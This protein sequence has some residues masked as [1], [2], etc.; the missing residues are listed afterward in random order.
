MRI[1]TLPGD[2]GKRR[3]PTR[4]GRGEGSGK[5]K[6]CGRGTKGY[7]SRSGS[8]RRWGDEGGQMPLIQRLPKRGFKPVRK[9]RY[10]A[11]NVGQLEERFEAGAEIG[12]EALYEARLVRKKTGPV[13]ILAEGEITKPLVVRAHA[14]SAAAREKIAKAGGKC[15]PIEMRR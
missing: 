6:T 9:V 12:P 1:E 7:Q 10:H 13:K 8:G 4:V 5:G 15:E 3:K 2:R 14:F 11:V